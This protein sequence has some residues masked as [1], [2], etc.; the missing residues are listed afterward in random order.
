M[1]LD[2]GRAGTG[3]EPARLAAQVVSGIGFR[4]RNDI[5]PGKFHLWFDH[6]CKFMDQRLY[7]AGDRERLLMWVDW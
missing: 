1:D 5:A 4:R 3:G 6:S 7:R 2:W